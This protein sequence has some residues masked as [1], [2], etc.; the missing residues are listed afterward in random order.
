LAA[1]DATDCAIEGTVSDASREEGLPVRCGTPEADIT[2]VGGMTRVSDLAG[3]DVLVVSMDLTGIF[4]APVAAFFAAAGLAAVIGDVLAAGRFALV[5]TDFAGTGVA[6]LA[7]ALPAGLSLS[8]F[9]A[10][11]LA[12]VFAAVLAFAGVAFTSS[13]LTERTC[14]WALSSNLPLGDGCTPC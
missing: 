12:G 6:V 13:L 8:D 10:T 3:L 7:G 2:V 4:F 14:H 9:V 1:V 11:V 5:G